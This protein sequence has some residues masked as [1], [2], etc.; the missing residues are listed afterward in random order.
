MARSHLTFRR[1]HS[2]QEYA[3]RRRFRTGN[4]LL[5]LSNV[6]VGRTRDLED[7]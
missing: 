3:G 4:G 1:R 7:C 6:R 5:I 2:V